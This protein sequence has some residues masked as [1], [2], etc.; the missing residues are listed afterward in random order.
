MFELNGLG[1]KRLNKRERILASAGL[2]CGFSS[3]DGISVV[4]ITVFGTKVVVVVVVV[5]DR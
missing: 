1:W 4:E 2:F 5:V 3:I